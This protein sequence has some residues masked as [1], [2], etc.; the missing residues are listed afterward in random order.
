MSPPPAPGTSRPR[1]HIREDLRVR[2]LLRL[3]DDF[4][5]EGDIIAPG[6]VILGDR[7]AIQGDVFTDGEIVQGRDCVIT[8]EVRPLLAHPTGAALAAAPTGAGS[9]TVLESET[10]REAQAAMRFETVAAMLEILTDLIWDEPMSSLLQAQRPLEELDHDTLRD[11]MAGLVDLLD[12]TYRPGSAG[13]VW[14]PDE[15]VT[16]LYQRIAPLAVPVEATRLNPETA[17]LVVSRPPDLPLKAGLAGWPVR[18]LALLEILTA[19]VDPAARLEP[20]G[21]EREVRAAANPEK[22]RLTVRFG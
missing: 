15:V 22:V 14:S 19:T 6:G 7:V 21:G 20:A 8:G 12:Q 5:V 17:T 18:A 1:R 2:G 16:L 9:G 11:M 4:V 3:G 10:T 13:E